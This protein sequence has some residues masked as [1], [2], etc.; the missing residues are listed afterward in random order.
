ML[1]YYVQ[2][3]SF[4]RELRKDFHGCMEKIAAAGYAGVEL[5]DKIYGGY[6][7]ASLEKYLE[8]LNMVIIGA[9][10]DL[11]LI[12]EQLEYFFNT[13][14]KYIVC[15]GIHVSSADEAISAARRF[16]EYGRQVAAAGMKFGYHNHNSDFDHYEGKSVIEI[17]IESTDP[18]LVTFELDAAWAWRS[19]IDAQAFIAEH[20]NRF[21]LI[22]L[23]ETS[24]VLT[25]EDSFEAMIKKYGLT[26]G[27]NGRPVMN[28]AAKAA[29]AEHIKINC[30]LGKGLINP[31][32][33]I[34]TAVSQGANAFIVEREYAYTGD[35]FTSLA[36]DAAYLY[37][38]GL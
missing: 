32:A 26:I 24:R 28:E 18:E 5:F 1:K 27:E 20:V 30:A 9:H 31:P 37:N 34:P 2:T 23:K 21:E 7:S 16:N 10:V 29:F 8:S 22:H 38:L 17:F 11:E 3:A 33:L 19:G 15:P 36:E 35:I 13:E 12:P 6:S 25:P 4:S 14:C